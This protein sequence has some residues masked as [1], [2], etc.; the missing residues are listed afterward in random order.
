MT[1][2]SALETEILMAMTHDGAIRVD[3]GVILV[4]R[5]NLAFRGGDYVRAF[6]SLRARN[7]LSWTG[8]S[9]AGGELYALS[10][11][12]KKAATPVASDS[13]AS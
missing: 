8:H 3:N 7:F 6:R 11:E 5:S 1:P 13:P 10:E 2:L 9:V 4:M 12:G